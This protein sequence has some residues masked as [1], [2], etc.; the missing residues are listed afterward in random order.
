M[1]AMYL[2][3]CVASWQGTMSIPLAYLDGFGLDFALVRFLDLQKCCWLAHLEAYFSV[4]ELV[5]QTRQKFHL[6]SLLNEGTEI[7]ALYT[8]IKTRLQI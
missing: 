7:N 3:H 8:G 6:S 2:H 4:A 5:V 1:K